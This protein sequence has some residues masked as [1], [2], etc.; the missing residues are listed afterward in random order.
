M[1]HLLVVEA[2]IVSEL[3]NNGLTHFPHGLLPSGGDAVDRAAKYR[4]L[5]WQQR[6]VVRSLGKRH[7]AVDAQKFRIA[8]RVVLDAIEVF[9]GRL[10]FDGDEDILNEVGESFWKRFQRL[11]DHAFELPTRQLSL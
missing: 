3:V 1:W 8:V 2:E 11:V 4:D 5:V 10:L 6:H 9:G 7:A